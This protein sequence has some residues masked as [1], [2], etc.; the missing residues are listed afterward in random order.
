MIGSVQVL[1]EMRKRGA[2]CLC[3][4]CTS[5]SESQKFSACHEQVCDTVLYHD[6]SNGTIHLVCS[7]T[8]ATCLH[9]WYAPV[10]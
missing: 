4:L 2:R 3:F 1:L 7:V 6:D 8:Y 10:Q 9:N 5:V